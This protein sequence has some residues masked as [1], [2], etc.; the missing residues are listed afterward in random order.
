MKTLPVSRPSPLRRKIGPTA[1]AAHKGFTLIELLV[2]IAIIAILIGLLLPA[3]QKVRE[4]AARTQCTNNLKQLGLAMHNYHDS[5]GTFPFEDGPTSAAALGNTPPSIYVQILPY[6]EQQNLY[7]QMS[8]QAGGLNN[9]LGNQTLANATSIK[10]FL[11]PARRSI[12][13]GK[14]DYAGAYNGGISEADI[15]NYYSEARGYKSILNTP[16][17]TMAVVTSQAGTANTLLLGHK[18][19]RPLNYNGIPSTLANPCPTGTSCK[20]LGWAVTLKTQTGYDHMRWADTFAGG[21]NA[22]KGLWKDDN[23]VDE[24][25]FGGPHTAGCPMLWADGSVRMYTYGYSASGLSDDATLQV[26]FAFNR[27]VP[28]NAP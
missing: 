24:N 9:S 11:C 8:A 27:G 25:H 14:V 1:H 19:L 12:G 6:V 10:N 23:G 17:T 26:L 4:A 3:V 16:G 21:T 18:I 5:I 2:V 15:T 7:Q 13:L 28:V 22:H 20:D